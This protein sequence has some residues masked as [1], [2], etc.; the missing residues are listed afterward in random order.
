MAVHQL[1][2]GIPVADLDGALAWYERLFGRPPDLLPNDDEACWQL[3]EGSWVYVVRDAGRAGNALLTPLVA[4]LDAQV[5]ELAA[6]G[7]ATDPI[8]VIPGAA[9]K[10]EIRDPEGNTITFGQPLQD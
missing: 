1:F 7:L 6:R 4:D 3:A 2:A 10:A 8:E 5:A 9:R